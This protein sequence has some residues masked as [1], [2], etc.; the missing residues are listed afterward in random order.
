MPC[1]RR[2]VIVSFGVPGIQRLQFAFFVDKK[3]RFYGSTTSRKNDMLQSTQNAAAAKQ[4]II[5]KLCRHT[6]QRIPCSVDINA[7]FFARTQ[8]DS[9]HYRKTLEKLHLLPHLEDEEMQQHVM[10]VIRSKRRSDARTKEV[11]FVFLLSFMFV[12]KHFQSWPLFGWRKTE[13]FF[14]F[15]C[16]IRGLGFYSSFW[17][18]NTQMQ[19]N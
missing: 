12:A 5:I 8:V 13:V 10:D 16:N 3:V 1:A 2:R 4:Q 18:C 6:P 9:R 19:K 11:H 17:R 15:A 7:I 14:I